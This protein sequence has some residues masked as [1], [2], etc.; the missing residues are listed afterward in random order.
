VKRL[1]VLAFCAAL[2]VSLWLLAAPT[3]AQNQG[4]SPELQA[5]LK[6][7][8]HNCSPCHGEKGDG[9][10]IAAPHLLP[11]PR[12]FTAAK[13]R[14][15]S[16]PTGSLPTDADLERA[17]R[18]GLPYTA[19][20]AFDWMSDAEIKSLVAAVKSFSSDFQDPELEPKPLDLPSPPSTSP[21]LVKQGRKVYQAT[22][23]TRCHGDLGRADGPSARTLKDDTG[24]RIWP[25]DLT[26]PWTFRGGGSRS[27]IFRTL[28][29][30]FNGTPMPG[31]ADALSVE[32][33]WQITDYIASLAWHDPDGPYGELLTAVGVGGTIDLNN[34]DDLFAQAPKTLFPIF[35]QIVQPGREF[36]PPV[37][38]IQAQAIYNGTDIA[39]RLTWHDHSAE[40]SGHNA[41]DL[42]VAK[43]PVLPPEQPSATPAKE[44]EGSF[45]GDA[46]AETEP[47][48]PAAQQEA[49]PEDQSGGFWE[50]G[51]AAEATAQ[52]PEAEFS[53]AVGIQ[54]P[55]TMPTGI[56]KPYFLFGDKQDPVELWFAD[57]AQG[58]QAKL[59]VAS[60][61]DAIESLS[62][63]K[64][65][66]HSSYADGAWT[67]TFK[68]PVR[69]AD[70][71]GFP[72]STFIPIAFTVWDGLTA[73]HGN[74][75]GLT[76]WFSLYLEPLNKP[77]PVVPM[78][79]AGFGVLGLELLLIGAVR[80][81]RRRGNS[82]SATGD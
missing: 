27:D 55:R 15:R 46:V 20:P 5:G 64:L 60:G 43:E 49:K 45:W 6:L 2:V 34:A 3:L 28:S 68:R 57:L 40:A 63:A 66:V 50:T 54:L 37:T 70:G 82:S 14:V 59:Y 52:A 77:S 47:E 1:G 61:S 65:E 75:R 71:L 53:D 31:F 48:Q 29:T 38:A 10:G 19:M 17:I 73:E 39:I 69:P 22:G 32:Q 7:Y 62:G 33:R 80:W 35:G 30:G 56:R 13:F 9:N 81:R 79:K 44:S 51:A 58:D 4:A 42:P 18:H 8:Q 67:V 26:M 25:A 72:Q 24:N 74:K 11:K 21:D 76:R 36:H 12:D 78:L 16:T 23:C 41:P